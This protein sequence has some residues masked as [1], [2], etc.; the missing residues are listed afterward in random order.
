MKGEIV[1]DFSI[2]GE[3]ETGKTIGD[4]Y[5]EEMVGKTINYTSN[6]ALPEGTEWIILGEDKDGSIMLTTSKPIE[7]GFTLNGTAEAWLSYEEDIKEACSIYG[8]TIQGKTVTARSITLEDV[9]RVTGFVEPEFNT[10]TFGSTLDFD[11]KKVNYYH[12]DAESENFWSKEETTYENDAYYYYIDSSDN[13]V[14]YAY[15]GNSLSPETYTTSTLKN[16]DIILGENSDYMYLLGSR[17]VSVYSSYADFSVANVGEG[18]VVSSN[19]DLCDSGS[20][21]FNDSGYSFA[22]PVRPIINL[23]SNIQVEQLN[24]EWSI[25]D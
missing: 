19:F 21:G 9:N 23:P 14:K 6:T 24:G 4:V 2:L 7:N 11:N 5:S 1:I 10:Y 12:P 20:D 18:I 25:V 8:A 13:T 17:S 3:T 15:E 22:V 16:M